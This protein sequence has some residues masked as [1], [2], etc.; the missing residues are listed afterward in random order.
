MVRQHS[1]PLALPKLFST[2][3]PS[4]KGWNH[5]KSVIHKIN[6]DE[7][8][9]NLGYDISKAEWREIFVDQSKSTNHSVFNITTISTP[10][11]DWKWDKFYPKLYSKPMHIVGSNNLLSWKNEL[12]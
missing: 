12:T 2:I 5:Y 7:R 11:D 10:I 1:N 3:V 9:E 4:L 6:P 8:S